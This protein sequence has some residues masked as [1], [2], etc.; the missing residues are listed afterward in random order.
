MPE[1]M[2]AE[3]VADVIKAALES[4]RRLFLQGLHD[5]DHIESYSILTSSNRMQVWAAY[6]GRVCT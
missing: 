4:A 2:T 6:P 3:Q 5:G 1:T